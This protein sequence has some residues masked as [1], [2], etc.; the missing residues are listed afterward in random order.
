MSS[1]VL[2]FFNEEESFQPCTLKR[3]HFLGMT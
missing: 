2:G 1:N 3:K